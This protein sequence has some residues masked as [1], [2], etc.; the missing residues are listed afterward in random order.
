MYKALPRGPYG[1]SV[2]SFLSGIFLPI[3]LIP[4]S[5][6]FRAVETTS[7]QCLKPFLVLGRELSMEPFQC[8]LSTAV[9][10]VVRMAVHSLP[11]TDFT[12]LQ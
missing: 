7:E 4:E 1:G 6:E 9:T 10:R 3:L 8:L 11:Y 2:H 12:R 5:I